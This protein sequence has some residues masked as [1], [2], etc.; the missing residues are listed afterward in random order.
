[1]MI[2]TMWTKRRILHVYVNVAEMG[3]GVFGAEAASRR[4]FHKSASSLSAPEAALLAAVLPNP[5]ECRVD[6]P[7]PHLKRR[8]QWILR[9]MRALGGE[10][11]LKRLSASRP[12]S[13]FP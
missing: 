6:A 5:A 9:Q 1:V 12:A 2:E 10:G 7:S 13:G 8:Q 4:F 11:W 3:D